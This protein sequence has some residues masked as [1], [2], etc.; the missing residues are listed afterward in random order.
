M[1][2]SQDVIPDIAAVSTGDEAVPATR[3]ADADGGNL[4][5]LILPESVISQRLQGKAVSVLPAL[6][7]TL[8][9]VQLPVRG[10]AQKLAALP[11][12]LEEDLGQ[13]VGETHHALCGE[14]PDGGALA[15]TLSRAA[16]AAVAGPQP[17]TPEQF[18]LPV[19]RP[20]EGETVRW[21]VWRHGDR[22]LVRASDGTGFGARVDMLAHLWAAAGR[23]G[24]DSHGAALPS[25]F[26]AEA[27]EDVR[28]APTGPLPDLRQGAFAPPQRLRAPAIALV[29]T[30]LLALGGHLGLAFADLQRQRAT[31]EALRAEATALLASNLPGASV[32]D[33]PRLLYRRL[34]AGAQEAPGFLAVLSRASGALADTPVQLSNL[35]WSGREGT[36]TLEAEAPGIDQLQ[37]AEAALRAE[38]LEVAAGAVTAGGGSAR[39]TL[40]VRA[41]R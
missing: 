25:G 26:P 37:A 16:M 13:P 3:P 8:H 2:A 6:S 35:G 22:A 19:P 29:V 34:S 32:T 9:S 12:A 36:L 31:A 21:A 15:A 30:L 18:L 23:P 38:G 24:L 41:G 27:R 5:P 28:L 20:A 7:V 17:V 4:P 14:A 10:L 11:Y 1:Q 33:D 40:T 39:M